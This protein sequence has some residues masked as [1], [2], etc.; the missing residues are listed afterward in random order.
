M[1][2]F[3]DHPVH[4]GKSCKSCKSCQNFFFPRGSGGP[5]R[6]TLNRQRG[7]TLVE[8]VITIVVLGIAVGGVMMAYTTII[9]R[10]ADPVLRVQA[11]A[12]A[13]SYLEEITLRPV[14]DRDGVEGET[15]ANYDDVDDYNGLNEAP[16]DQFGNPVPGLSAYSVQVTV[17]GSTLNGP[18]AQQIVVTVTQPDGVSLSLTGYRTDY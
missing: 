11:A 2:R 17:A 6:D 3:P 1:T 14:T 15:R 4:P 12:V 18:A 10:S 7:F 9:A 13:E 5:H 16:T 8:L